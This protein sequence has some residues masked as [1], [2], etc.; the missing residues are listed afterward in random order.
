PGRALTGARSVIVCG[1][2]Y[3]TAHPH[4]IEFEGE[5]GSEAEDDGTPRAWI[6]RYAWGGDY[7]DVLRSRLNS[8][9]AE[10][11]ARFNEPFE[12]VAYAD[13]GPLQERIFAKYAGIGWIAKNTLVLN[14]RM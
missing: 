11:R 12:T 5:R 7:H 14:Q 4:S 3:N 10:L 2:N 1:L 6:S 9:V 13:T 8:L